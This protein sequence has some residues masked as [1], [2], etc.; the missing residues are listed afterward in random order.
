MERYG[1]ER[2]PHRISQ[3][4]ATYGNDRWHVT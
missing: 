4:S 2:E 3:T 1:A